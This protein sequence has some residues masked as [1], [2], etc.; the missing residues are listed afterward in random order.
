MLPL[1]FL[2]GVGVVH[3][4]G[5]WCCCDVDYALLLGVP[6]HVPLL[7]WL[8]PHLQLALFLSSFLLQLSSS[9]LLLACA[10]ALLVA[11]QQ[12]PLLPS[13]VVL[14]LQQ[15]YA[16]LR[17]QLQQLVVAHV[18][19]VPLTHC[20]NRETVSI[21]GHHKSPVSTSRNPHL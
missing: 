11:L 2:L 12:L 17:H 10:V 13:G 15:P 19:A 4:Y 3:D 9:L 8:Q 14:Q 6:V 5:Y 1:V 7:L 16:F 20:S 21:V 18:H